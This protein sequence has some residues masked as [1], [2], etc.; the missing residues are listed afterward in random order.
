MAGV[1]S[2]VLTRAMDAAL[3]HTGQR[4]LVVSVGFQT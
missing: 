1:S 2:T 4:E 3:A